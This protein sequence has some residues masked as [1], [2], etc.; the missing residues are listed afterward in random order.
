VPGSRCKAKK[1]RVR[2]P[3]SANNPTAGG[4]PPLQLGIPQAEKHQ[5]LFEPPRHRGTKTGAF[6]QAR[7]EFA[8]NL[9]AQA[10]DFAAQFVQFGSLDLKVWIHRLFLPLFL[11]SLCLCGLLEIL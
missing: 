3:G 10:D 7:P 6:E 9:N 11:L 5:V 8:V 2:Q 4:S 1:Q